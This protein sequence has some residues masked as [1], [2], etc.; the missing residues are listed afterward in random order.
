MKSFTMKT[1]ILLL[2]LL[3]VTIKVYSQV[4]KIPAGRAE[5][6]PKIEAGRASVGA[7]V[8]EGSSEIGKLKKGELD[9]EITIGC[10]EL[11]KPNEG[12]RQVF[13]SVFVVSRLADGSP[14][15][16]GQASTSYVELS[17]IDSLVKGIDYLEKVDKSVTKLDTFFATYMTAGGLSIRT[18]TTDSG[19]LVR[20]GD[21]SFMVP[22][23]DLG[24]FRTLIKQAKEKL[25]T[26]N[27]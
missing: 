4:D 17:E 16:R 5:T 23:E 27:K 11:I 12:T 21:A 25:D 3:S 19:L 26:I 7:V 15:D 10:E 14:T 20:S 13:L 24:R 8:V 9:G 18:G 6:K 22:K 1:G 2:L